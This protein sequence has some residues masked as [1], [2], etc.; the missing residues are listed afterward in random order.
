M[1]PDHVQQML[2]ETSNDSSPVSNGDAKVLRKLMDE[3]QDVL[4]TDDFGQALNATVEVGFSHLMDLMLQCFLRTNEQS[5]S[6]NSSTSSS[7][8]GKINNS[9]SGQFT[10]PNLVSIHLARLLPEMKKVL[11]GRQTTEEK[12]SLVREILCQ[13]LLNCY[14][15]N[16]YEAFCEAKN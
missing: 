14:S 10:N 8:D 3:T 12:Q 16:V 15:A 6:T 5:T 7:N 1:N 4:E 2:D 13:D 11:E 9:S